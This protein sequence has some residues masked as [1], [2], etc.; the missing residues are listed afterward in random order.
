VDHDPL[1]V[2]V[3]SRN[4]VIRL[5]LTQLLDGHGDD[6]TVV[7]HTAAH[8]GHLRGADVVVYDLTGSTPTEEAD[9]AHLTAS[10]TPVVAVQPHPH[11]DLGEDA[12]VTGVTEL[13]GLDVTAVELLA[14]VERAATGRSAELEERRSTY[15]TELQRRFGL[16]ERELDVL[17]LV[18]SA[19]TNEEIARDLFLSINSVK[20]YIRTAYAKIGAGTR[21]QAV[22]WA[23]EHGLAHPERAAE[24]VGGAT[25]RTTDGEAGQSP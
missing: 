16:T 13:V 17:E 3:V 2:A 9:L 1:R 14:A 4:E 25:Y 18:A 19:R 10:R 23:I 15:R 24:P 22:L 8:D 21:P 6:R 11:S 20:S 7:V 12:R 5:G